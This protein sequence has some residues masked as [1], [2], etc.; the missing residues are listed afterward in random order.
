MEHPQKKSSPPLPDPSNNKPHRTRIIIHNT[1]LQSE[2]RV[3]ATK[4][5]FRKNVVIGRAV[6]TQNDGSMRMGNLIFHKPSPFDS[7]TESFY[8]K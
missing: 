5:S 4:K 8:F 6:H 3:E 2:D 7:Q 1:A